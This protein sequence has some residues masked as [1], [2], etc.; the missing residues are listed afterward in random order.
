[1][2]Y[3]YVLQQTQVTEHARV[4][5]ANIA[6]ASAESTVR[7]AAVREHETRERRNASVRDTLERARSRSPQHFRPR[8]YRATSTSTS[9]PA[10]PPGA[11]SFQALHH[12]HNPQPYTPR[13]PSPASTPHSFELHRS[14]TI[15]PIAHARSTGHAPAQARYASAQE[16][17][18]L[19]PRG[20]GGYIRSLARAGGEGGDAARGARGEGV[21]IEAYRE[22]VSAARRRLHHL[23]TRVKLHH[24]RERSRT[25]HYT[26][27]A[28]H[29]TASRSRSRSP[30]HS[31]RH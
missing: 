13:A 3:C 22:R 29:G 12:I 28:G 30:Q 2:A 20:D 23:T 7:E 14:R 6:R 31:H 11:S 27:S 25:L 5:T 21:S 8:D 26:A 10:M 19:L 24:E 16:S 18:D 15:S 9:P 4:G 17:G 1:M